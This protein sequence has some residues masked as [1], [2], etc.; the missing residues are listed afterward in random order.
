VIHPRPHYFGSCLAD[1][2][3][4][5]FWRNQLPSGTVTDEHV[6]GPGPAFG[7]RTAA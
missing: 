7:L 5:I 4:V 3:D 6:A 2:R 1:L